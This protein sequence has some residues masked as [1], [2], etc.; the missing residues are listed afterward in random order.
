MVANSRPLGMR[1]LGGVRVAVRKGGFVL[2]LLTATLVGRPDAFAG[3]APA[4]T[5]AIKSGLSMA[6][7]LPILTRIAQIRNL[8][9]EEVQR[10]YPLCIRA[11]VTYYDPFD[12]D[13]FIQDSTVGIWVN[14]DGSPKLD[15]RSGDL[16]EVQGLT[17]W[18]DFSPQIGKPSIKVVGRSAL[19]IPRRASFSL[20]SSTSENSRWV[21]VEGTVLDLTEQKERGLAR[22]TLQLDD[23][24]INARVLTSSGAIPPNLLGAKIRVRGVDSALNNKKNQLIGV[25]LC[26]PSLAELHV[27]EQGPTDLFDIP[28]H[29]IASLLRFTPKEELGRVKVQGVVTLQQ[30]G[31]GLFIQDGNEGLFVESYEKTPLEV[32]DRVAVA[33]FP[34]MGSGY[35]PILRNALFHSL[36]TGAEP[37]PRTVGIGEVLRGDHDSEL[38]RIKGRLLHQT[39]LNGERVLTLDVDSATVRADLKTRDPD[40][41]L[42]NLELGSLLQVTGVCSVSVDENHEPVGFRILLRS[43]HDITVLRTPSWWNATH[44]LGLMGVATLAGLVALTWVYVLRRRVRQQ[45]ETIRVRLESEAALE[46]RYQRLFERNLAG[47][48]RTSLDGLLLDCNNALAAMFGYSSREECIGRKVLQLHVSQ[49]DREAF[50]TELKAE[51]KISN[52]EMRLRRRD[53]SDVWVIENATLV[54][55]AEVGFPVIEGTYIDITERKRAEA[56]LQQAKEAAESAN[57]AKSE[58]VANMSHEI[59]TP[60]NGVLGMTDLLLDTELTPEQHD[61]LAM[62]KT[63]ADSLLTVINDILDFSKIEAGKMELETVD[64]KLCDCLDPALRTLRLRAQEKGLKLNWAIAADVPDTLCGDPGRLRQVL[65]NLLGNALKFT[66]KGGASVEVQLEQAPNHHHVS[67]HFAVRDTGIGI[68]PEKQSA[69]FESFTQ[70]DGSTARRYGGTGLGLTIS[71]RLVE[72]MGGRIWVESEAGRGSTFHFTAQFGVATTGGVAET[73]SQ[74]Q[75]QATHERRNGLRILLAEDNAVN[76]KVAVRLLEK[77][78]SSVVVANNGREALECLDRESFDLVL[79][80]VQMPEMDGFEATAAIRRRERLTGEHIPIIAMTAHAMQGDRDRC[81]DAGMDG[82]TSKPITASQLRSAIE[83]V[84]AGAGA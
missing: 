29:R 37:P 63:S 79:M 81:L 51:R 40:Q 11:V 55:N 23:G 69:I 6:A 21:E 16:V 58:F 17:E 24:V 25:R 59:R 1:Q 84:A 36:G 39:E 70:A 7:N 32:G 41:G 12:P 22:L 49:S 20:L 82:Y 42:A 75:A 76:Q 62:V 64:F 78:G 46:K 71:R 61:C 8:T 31:R 14:T 19:P 66:E 43:G 48:Y 80:D 50:L 74:S 68:S 2:A 54:D 27:E 26:I 53:G 56:Q 73:N 52:R 35:S 34:S 44:A 60:M 67:L 65:L 13:L 28:M 72:M 10:G 30:P 57:R 5:A 47:V 18:P 83:A 15:M 4:N 38:V 3:Q 77:Q 33:G 9:Q 45:T